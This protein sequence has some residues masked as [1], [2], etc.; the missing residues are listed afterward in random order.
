MNEWLVRVRE[1]FGRRWEDVWRNVLASPEI[2]VAE[3]IAERARLT[4]PVVWMLGKVQSGKSSIVKVLTGSGEAEIG[5]GFKACTRTARV[6]DF[7]AEAPVIRF[8]DTRGLGEARYDPGEDIAFCEGRAHLILVVIKALD[9]DQAAVVEAVGRARARHPEWPVVV[10]QT[11][12]H[13]GYQAG[14]TRHPS[15]YPFQLPSGSTKSNVAIPHDL[16]RSLARQRADFHNLP[17]GPPAAFVPIDFTLEKDGFD[18]PA[19]G[20]EALL[21]AL[22]RAAPA[23]VVAA[24]AA[25]HQADMDSRSRRA[26][27]HIVGYAMAA[28]AAD[29]LPV[30][31]LVAVP[32]IQAKLL[33]SLAHIYGRPWDRR[34]VAEFAG[35]LGAGTVLRGLS[36]FGVRELAKLVPGYGQTAGAAAAAAASFALTFALGKAA[37]AY[38]GRRKTGHIDDAA[39]AAAYRAALT[40]AFKMEAERAAAK[41]TPRPAA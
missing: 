18:P 4:A 10:A 5:T 3:E 6:F 25:S 34:Q 28:A 13:E 12:L 38:L 8:L 36:G 9:H 19:Y 7:P 41:T 33:H 37:C 24:L 40:E 35:A 1:A 15:P 2:G 17:G 29:L 14:V 22:Q 11:S 27:P 39:V 31:G 23:G 30:A 26:H 32:G 21:E 20:L 16:V